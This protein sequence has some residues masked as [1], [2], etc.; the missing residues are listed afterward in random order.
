MQV[1]ID[2]AGRIVLPKAVR[3]KL[4]LASG[5]S[6]KIEEQENAVIL[7]PMI[8]RPAVRKKDGMWMF[9]TGQPLSAAT[10]CQT[11]DRVRE[12]RGAHGPALGE[13]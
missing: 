8:E 1:K 2:N 11:L 4:K 5:D 6:L 10:V 7:S 9:R 12:E 13:E 3:D